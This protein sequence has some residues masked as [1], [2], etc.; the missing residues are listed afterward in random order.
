MKLLDLHYTT[1]AGGETHVELVYEHRRIGFC[2]EPPDSKEKSCWWIA[3]LPPARCDGSGYL[4]DPMPTADAIA[5]G[6]KEAV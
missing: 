3:S 5:R 6:S 4:D 1:L 2:F